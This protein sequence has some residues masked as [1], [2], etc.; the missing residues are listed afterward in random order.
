MDESELT[1]R[2][3]NSEANCSDSFRVNIQL[4]YTYRINIKDYPKNETERNTK[5]IDFEI[6]GDL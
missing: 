3:E 2:L 6:S 5:G 1:F 4:V